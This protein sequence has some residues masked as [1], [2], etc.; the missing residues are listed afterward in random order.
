MSNSCRFCRFEVG[1]V[2]VVGCRQR[3][4]ER[5]RESERWGG[6]D[7]D[8]EK[9]K[10]RETEKTERETGRQTDRQRQRESY[11]GRQTVDVIVKTWSLSTSHNRW[12]LNSQ[13]SGRSALSGASCCHVWSSPITCKD[14]DEVNLRIIRK[15]FVSRMT[16]HRRERKA[17]DTCY[18]FV[19]NSISRLWR[20]KKERKK[21]RKKRE[22]AKQTVYEAAHNSRKTTNHPTGQNWTRLYYC[23]GKRAENPGCSTPRLGSIVRRDAAQQPF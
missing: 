12:S 4:K 2:M 10:Q 21:E 6:R 5:N 16:F 3:L 22:E 23:T 20:R 9:E 17:S 13:Y 18:N 8:W 7:R 15:E 11:L 1:R 14:E 19:L